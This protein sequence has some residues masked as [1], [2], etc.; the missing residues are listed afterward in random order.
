[1]DP[2]PVAKLFVYTKDE[3]DLIHDWLTYHGMLFGPQNLVVVDN[4]STDR[5]VLTV[6]DAHTA[7]GGT[8]LR[9][10]RCITHY[11]EL[12]S[13]HMQTYRHTARFLIPLDTDEF[14]VRC[15]TQPPGGKA[16]GDNTPLTP[17][18]VRDILD[19][20][21][22]DSPDASIFRFADLLA[23]VVEPAAP[24]AG[25]ELQQH[26]RPAV[27]MTRFE[28]QGWDKV[29][30]AAAPFLRTHAG[31]HGGATSHGSRAP[32]SQLA[33]LHYHNTG[34]RRQLERCKMSLLGYNHMTPEQL[35][36]PYRQQ[37]ELCRGLLPQQLR[38][39]HRVEQYAAILKR[40]LVVQAFKRITCG[41][42]PS[43]KYV[44]DVTAL[45][46]P[47]DPGAALDSVNYHPKADQDFAH[48]SS[49]AGITEDDIVLHDPV[50]LNAKYQVTQVA[51]TLQHST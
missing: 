35:Q 36:L 18:E 5:R 29:Y 11:S 7:K 37:L 19:R 6:Y 51:V 27:Q 42:L 20:T 1:M 33:L 41:R 14:I 46:P 12:M 47:A 15:P 31:N 4:C 40:A 28:D 9:E 26:T 17:D 45:G 39:G 25:Y 22:A 21:Q 34:A 10:P 24:G 32:C 50:V 43:P 49:C 13:E 30:F 8:V 38:G 48:A 44:A 16:R 2:T 23:A 3:Y